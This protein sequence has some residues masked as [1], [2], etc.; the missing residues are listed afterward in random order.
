MALYT[1]YS[2]KAE[3]NGETILSFVLGTGPFKDNAIKI[4]SENG[5]VDPQPGKWY[6]QQ[7]WLDAFKSI[8]QKFG[9][10]TLKQIGKSIP[11]SAVFPPQI[12]SIEA[13]LEAINFAYHSNHR[14]GEIGN[15]IFKKTSERSAS[16][17]CDNPYPC[18][19]NEGLIQA[20]AERFKPSDSPIIHVAHT[21]DGNCIDTGN[22]LCTF[23]VKW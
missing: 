14:N 3:V 18:S 7:Y 12:N 6:S 16:I 20:M 19:F 21:Q 4:L 15:Y 9:K 23:T 17:T 2:P 11:S 10:N 22:G 5:I 8:S 13:A 1:A